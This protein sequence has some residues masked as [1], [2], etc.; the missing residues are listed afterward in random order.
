MVPIVNL[1]L[2]LAVLCGNV[3]ICASKKP[4]A[5]I[6][7]GPYETG[8][9]TIAEHLFANKDILRRKN[10]Y[11][12]QLE[13]DD[14]KSRASIKICLG[15]SSPSRAVIDDQRNDSRSMQCTVDCDEFYNFVSE[16]KVKN[17]TIIF[18]H[19]E[20]S[21]HMTEED[22]K[23]SIFELLSGYDVS[24]V[25]FYKPLT[26][27]LFTYH[28]QTHYQ[29]EDVLLVYFDKWYEDVMLRK[30]G[31]LDKTFVTSI[32]SGLV[33]MKYSTGN[34]DRHDRLYLV[35][36][37][38]ALKKHMEPHQVI[39]CDILQLCGADNAANDKPGSLVQNRQKEKFDKHDQ[40][41][42]N[43][44]LYAENHKCKLLK[45]GRYYIDQDEYWTAFNDKKLSVPHVQRTNEEVK[46]DALQNHRLL[47]GLEA[48]YPDEVK[49]L[50]PDQTMSLNTINSFKYEEID[51]EKVSKD[52][53]YNAAFQVMMQLGVR[54]S[55]IK[56]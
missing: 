20:L 53:G 37:N 8:S 5:I 26:T 13:C 50:Y 17:H 39:H 40:V 24:I 45:T 11:I 36:F 21:G 33:S 49:W 6:Y 1:V 31:Y 23:N 43:F 22:T 51:R 47:Y 44:R 29:D 34:Y 4:K 52:N 10:V 55:E 9:S 3:I 56:C 14:G 2:F 7:I 15:V 41:F 25:S 42:Y 12:P 28:T 27:R 19:E 18:G 35:D 16:H 38:G 46:K 54:R 32:I 48:L 30:G